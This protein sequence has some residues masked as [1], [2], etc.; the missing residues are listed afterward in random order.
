MNWEGEVVDLS[1]DESEQWGGVSGGCVLVS[2]PIGIDSLSQVNVSF[3]VVV[4]GS[5]CEF[6]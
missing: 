1:G 6:C 5:D 2:V 3:D 4:S